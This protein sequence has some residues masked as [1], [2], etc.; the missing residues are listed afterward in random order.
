MMLT[1][2]H[3]TCRTFGLLLLFN[4][5]Y[6]IYNNVKSLKNTIV[7]YII[8]IAYVPFTI[9]CELSCLQLR[10][11]LRKHSYDHRRLTYRV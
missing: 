1:T 5:V 3:F 2:V 4:I 10:Y 9:L 7:L 6:C 8:E 11:H